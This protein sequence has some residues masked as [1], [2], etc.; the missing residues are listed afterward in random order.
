MKRALLTLG[1]VCAFFA[2]NAQNKPADNHDGHNH[3]TTTPTTAP[4][5]TTTTTTTAPNPNAAAF[6][7]EAEEYNFGTVKQGES[8]NY[9]F[10]FVN[11]GKENL[12]IDNAHGSCGCTVPTYPKDPVKPGETGIIKVTF[13]STGKMGPQDKTVTLNSNAGQKVLHLKGTVEAKPAE[14]PFPTKKPTDG[15]PVEKNN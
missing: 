3:G 1:I 11:S 2:A 10:K 8:V 14:E 7:F 15:A 6:K 5:T 13:N 9:E 4:T 12:V